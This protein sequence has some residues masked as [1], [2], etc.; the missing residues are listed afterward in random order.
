MQYLVTI[1][2]F[3]VAAIGSVWL[4]VAVL[5][6]LTSDAVAI[7]ALLAAFLFP[8][9]LLLASLLQPT[10]DNPSKIRQIAAALEALQR[11][12]V[13]I[14]IAYLSAI[15]SFIIA[16]G[17][18][19]AAD[20]TMLTGLHHHGVGGRVLSAMCCGFSTYALGR[21]LLVA[22]ALMDLQ[23]LRHKW[24]L[25]DAA[26]LHAERVHHLAQRVKPVA[27]PSDVPPYARSVKV[28]ED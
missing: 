26:A 9:M 25:A 4:P 20:T 22:R 7:F 24:V 12:A 17:V 10:S 6:E 5:A 3:V 1:A 18:L 16:K 14:F 13:I 27:A 11:G 23:K 21:T 15:G 8:Y 28:W 2:A 19:A